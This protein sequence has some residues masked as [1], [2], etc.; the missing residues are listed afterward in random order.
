[1]YELLLVGTDPPTLLVN[2]PFERGPP[3]CHEDHDQRHEHAHHHSR[4]AG[5][6]DVGERAGFVDLQLRKQAG[7]VGEGG[8]RADGPAR[9]WRRSSLRSGE[10][11]LRFRRDL[12]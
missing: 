1:M 5:A 3:E 12:W 2:L 8:L 4:D 10:D 6:V 11:F 7:G 9:E